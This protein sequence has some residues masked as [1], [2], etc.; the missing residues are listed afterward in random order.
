MMRLLNCW[1]YSIFGKTREGS[2]MYFW[3]V[4]IIFLGVNTNLEG[5][6]GTRGRLNPPTSRQIEHWLLIYINIQYHKIPIAS[7]AISLIISCNGLSCSIIFQLDASTLPI[8]HSTPATFTY[9]QAAVQSTT[10]LCSKC[11][12]HLNLPHLVT[13]ATLHCIQYIVFR[14]GLELGKKRC[15]YE[16]NNHSRSKFWRGKLRAKPE[17]R[18]RSARELRAKPEPRAKPEIERGRG[19]GRGLGE[20]LLR[21]FLKI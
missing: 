7:R 11:S 5:L 13:S 21:K 8:L 4:W 10:L 17:A 3:L 6:R 18:A 16:N 2:A 20:P 15:W 14:S 12:N 9:L 1:Q 19:L